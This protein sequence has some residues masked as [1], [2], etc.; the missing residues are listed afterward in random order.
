LF[1]FGYVGSI[2]YST[3]CWYKLWFQTEYTRGN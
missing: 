3:W 1:S 2:I